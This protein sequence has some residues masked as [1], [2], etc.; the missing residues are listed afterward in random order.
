MKGFH[1]IRIQDSVWG[2]LQIWR[3]AEDVAMS[4]KDTP[5]FDRIPIVTGQSLSH[6][7]HGFVDPLMNE[8]GSHPKQVIL[9]VKTPCALRKT[10][11]S[12]GPYCYPNLKVPECYEP[13]GVNSPAN[14][15]AS[16]ITMCW[17]AGQ[18]VIRVQGEEFVI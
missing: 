4:V 1:F 10:C 3:I 14:T 9:R 8:I 12:A 18:Y 13:E 17:K 2:D 6:A 15:V 7:L 11:L 16:F 5:W